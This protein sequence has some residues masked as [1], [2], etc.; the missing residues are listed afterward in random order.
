M[1]QTV[2]ERS[3]K[4]YDAHRE[5][6]CERA[7]ERRAAIPNNPKKRGRKPGPIGSYK[8]KWIA[9]GQMAVLGQQAPA[10]EPAS[11]QMPPEPAQ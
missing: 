4:Y 6:I 2:A 9:A 8:E 1:P 10:A 7:R 5:E 11:E 3:K